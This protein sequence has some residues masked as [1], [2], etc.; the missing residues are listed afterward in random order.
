[1]T[2]GDDCHRGAEECV[3]VVGEEDSWNVRAVFALPGDHQTGNAGHEKGDEEEGV[4][5]F[6][7]CHEREP[8]L[9]CGISAHK[10]EDEEKERAWK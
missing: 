9:F 6:S 1:M 4:P 7:L 2:E 10:I 5:E 3:I 8:F